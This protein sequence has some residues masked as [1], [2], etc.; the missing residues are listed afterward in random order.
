M[1]R[2]PFHARARQMGGCRRGRASRVGDGAP[3]TCAERAGESSPPGPGSRH[4]VS[5]DLGMSIEKRLSALKRTPT[6]CGEE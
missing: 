4:H 3:G 5:A 6:G 1:K 2:E